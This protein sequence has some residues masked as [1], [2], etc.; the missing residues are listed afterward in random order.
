MEHTADEL[1]RP[2]GHSVR[3]YWTR[4]TISSLCNALSELGGVLIELRDERGLVL[5]ASSYHHDHGIERP[6]PPGAT[7]FPVVLNEETIGS[8]VVHPEALTGDKPH[9]LIE[10]I[11][12]LIAMTTSEMCTDVAQ[13]RYRVDE[14][15]VLYRLSSLLVKG[16]SV[17]DTLRL[18]LELALDVLHLDAGAIMLL[19]EDSEALPSVDLE[20]E[21]QRSASVELSEEWLSNPIPLS[22]DREFDRLSLAGKVVTSEDLSADPRVLVPDQCRQENLVAFLGTGMVFD[23]RPIGVIRLYSR[24]PRK[25]SSPERKLIKSIGESAAAAVEQARLLRMQARQRRVERA[26]RI[27]GAVQKRML[28]EVTPSY[29]RIGLA[30]RYHPS[31]E[32]GGDFYDLF[33]AHGQLGILVGDVVG[34]GVVAGM[35]MSA[36][37]ATIRAYTEG[38]DEL[39]KVMFRT[40]NAVCRDTTIAEFVTI[41]YGMIDPVSLRLRYAVAG[42]D[43]PLLMRRDRDGRY[44]KH[45][46]E[47][48]GMVVGVLPGE[49]YTMQQLQLRPG[50]LLVAYTDGITDAVNF[51]MQRFGRRRLADTVLEYLQDFPHSGAGDVLERVFWSMRQFSGLARQADDE[52]LVVIKIAD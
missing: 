52:T 39:D 40:N 36:V 12:E 45:A 42:H 10:R 35:L 9:D 23:A 28:P 32:I 18:S 21:L 7:V 46:L 43:Q 22:I 2:K 13:L 41:W 37:R 31:Q 51:D 19:P 15:A 20:N 3:D 27:A 24:T 5:D 48:G 38:T 47:G 14:V 50:D 1:Q 44:Q 29:E 6:V 33:E 16:G 25:F 49:R 26:L 8:V 11:G 30:A 17:D 4:G 34:K